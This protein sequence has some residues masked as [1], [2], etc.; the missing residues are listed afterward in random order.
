ML[1][2]EHLKKSFD[3]LVVWDDLNTVIHRGEIISIQGKSG[4]G[5]TTFLRCLNNLETVDGGTITIE[6]QNL[7]WE[8]DGK[9]N[10]ADG[11]ELREI[12]KKIGMVFQNFNLF[13][14]MTV[15]ENLL[16]GPRYLNL[17]TEEELKCRARELLKSMDLGDKE[18]FLPYQLSGGQKQRV[19]I[20]RACMQNPEI[21]CFDEPTSA[22]D[23]TTRDQI[24]EI[25]KKL[26]KNGMTILIV[27]HD[28]TFAK[29]ISHRILHIE[30]GEFREE[31]I[32]S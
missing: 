13:P 18:D 31:K 23:E 12:R 26:A 2:I 27:T 11:N 4:E 15:L 29:S 17:G 24:E 19:A 1:S 9:I 32:A 10:Y 16:L 20:A 8:K 30:E 21:L 25:I 14:H 5:K 28:N 3:D 7:V 6:G 22:L